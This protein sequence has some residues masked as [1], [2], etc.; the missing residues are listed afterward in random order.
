MF[1]VFLTATLERRATRLSPSLCIKHVLLFASSKFDFLYLLFAAPEHFFHW[2][3]VPQ[4]TCEAVF[5]CIYRSSN[6]FSDFS[7]ILI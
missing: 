4:W 1:T 5:E 3:Y 6:K 2:F 7:F